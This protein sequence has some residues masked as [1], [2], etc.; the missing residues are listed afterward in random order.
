MALITA[1]ELAEAIGTDATRAGHLLAAAEALV[2]EYAP[3]APDAIKREAIIRC[4][5]WLAEQPAASVRSETTGPF[6]MDWTQTTSA[7]RS[8]G[9]MGLL[10]RWKVR[11]AGAIG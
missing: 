1:A 8:S 10:T 9:A 7:L 6:T 11:R 4:S 3:N 2:N 5:G